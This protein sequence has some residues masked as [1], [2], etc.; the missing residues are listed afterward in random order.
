MHYATT[1]G[2]SGACLENDDVPID[3]DIAILDELLVAGRV[4][5]ADV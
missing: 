4:V 2:E 1:R 5:P 3:G